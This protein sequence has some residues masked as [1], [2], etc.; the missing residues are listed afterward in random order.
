MIALTY[1]VRYKLQ[2]LF[3]VAIFR[4]NDIKEF[5]IKI[6]EGRS[7]IGPGTQANLCG[8]K[9]MTFGEKTEDITLQ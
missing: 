8:I 4:K 6:R 1:Y 9:Q 7:S 2:A 5:D 3:F